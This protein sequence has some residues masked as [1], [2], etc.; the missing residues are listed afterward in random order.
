MSCSGGETPVDL[1]GLFDAEYLSAV[2]FGET[3]I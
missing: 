2:R 1:K 3:I